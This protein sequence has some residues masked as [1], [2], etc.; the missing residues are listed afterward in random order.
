MPRLIQITDVFER[1]LQDFELTSGASLASELMRLFPEPFGMPWKLY[2]GAIHEDNRMSEGQIRS[3]VIG[4]SDVYILILTPGATLGAEFF[5]NVFIALFFT[6]LSAFFQP[7]PKRPQ[8]SFQQEA[9]ESGNNAVAGQTNVL[10]PAARVPEI[11]GRVRSYPDLLTY[12]VEIWTERTQRIEQFFVIGV[13]RYA[14]SEAKLG[15]TPLESIGIAEAAYYYPQDD[16]YVGDLLPVITVMRRSAEISSMSLM[17]EQTAVSSTRLA[18]FDASDSTVTTQIRIEENGVIEVS[19]TAHN[20]NLYR[21]VTRPDSSVTTP[22]FVYEIEGD[23]AVTDEAGVTANIRGWPAIPLGYFISDVT[24]PGYPTFSGTQVQFKGYSDILFFG[25]ANGQAVVISAPTQVP[26]V[27]IVRNATIVLD[28]IPPPIPGQPVRKVFRFEVELWHGGLYDFGAT[29]SDSGAT[30]N[31]YYPP[32]SGWPIDEEPVYSLQPTPTSWYRAPMDAP[33]SVWLDIS[34]PQGLVKYEDNAANAFTV[35]VKAEFRRPGAS[36]AQDERTLPAFTHATT[37]PLR[38]TVQFD[39][40]T[41]TGLPAGDGVEVRLTR[42]TAIPQDTATVQYINETR[43]EAFSAVRTMPRRMYPDVTIARV[44]LTNTRS[45]V[46]LGENTFNVVATRVLP[47]WSGSAWTTPNPGGTRRWADNFVQRCKAADGAARG[48]EHIDLAG[49]YALQSQLDAIDGGAQGQI[50]LTL[51]Q[52]QDIDAELAQIA[53]V[54]RAQVYRVGR[55]I[56]VVRDQETTQ[57][58]ALFNGRNKSVEGETYALRMK[59][60]DEHDAVLV[61]W[62]DELA[63]YKMREL[64]YSDPPNPTPTNILRVSPLCAN[65]AQAWRRAVYEMNRVKFRREQVTCKVTEDG[66]LCRPGDVIH[67]TDDVANIAISAGEVIEISGSVLT[68]DKPVTFDAGTYTLLVRDV[69]G[70]AMDAIPVT[71]VAGS[72]NKVQLSRAPVAGVAMKARDASMGTLYAFYADGSATVR[73]WL[74]TQVEMSGPY[75]Q[76][77]AVNYTDRVYAGDTATLP[78]R[79]P[80]L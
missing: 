44:N 9:R 25:P 56:F 29:R 75:V 31:F 43:W 64:Q 15:D 37:G 63:A 53:D 48:D 62:V 65:W 36:A 58:I 77:G 39:L 61:T 4:P 5:V 30:A 17:P 40:S 38:W 18:T 22:P 10:R 24:H 80:L 79:P 78:A 59:G 34:F 3:C 2:A 27:G 69:A 46:S 26:V 7:R 1:E 51:D 28:G 76:L 70:I 11:L 41:L 16:Y 35:E 66:R 14:L 8:Q 47:S 68:L 6:T 50:G 42:L 32:E 67:M 60:E 23:A 74:L 52:Q 13:G 72:P 20:D 57:R 73:P 33:E 55:K 71:A 19:G 21:V 49:I 54:I 12:P 45:A